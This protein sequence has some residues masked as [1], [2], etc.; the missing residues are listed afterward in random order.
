MYFLAKNAAVLVPKSGVTKVLVQEAANQ[1]TSTSRSVETY[2]AEMER[3]A[4]MLP[5]CPVVM[6]MYGVG[7]SFGP[8][9]MAE[10]GDVRRFERKQALVA[11]ADIDPMP[12]QSG[13]KTAR[14]DKS[15]K[16]GSP[17]LRKTLFNVKGI[18]NHDECPP[19]RY[20]IADNFKRTLP[21]Q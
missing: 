15:S 13:D 2:R 12:D 4:S 21:D 14:S 18:D 1:L 6:K 10:T 8:Q 16:H 19:R 3:L 20:D 9:L 17:Y 5:E 7:K 11:F